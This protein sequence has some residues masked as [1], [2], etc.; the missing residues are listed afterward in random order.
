MILSRVISLVPTPSDV[1]AWVDKYGL[2]I[3][4]LLGLSIFGLW[5]LYQGRKGLIIKL[6]EREEYERTELKK[7]GERAIKALENN[8][9]L[10]SEIKQSNNEM[11]L[12]ISKHEESLNIIIKTHTSK[13]LV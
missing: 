12:L 10:L 6:N 2:D 1:E 7:I 11:K 4:I 5:M 13:G 3:V 8:N 9:S